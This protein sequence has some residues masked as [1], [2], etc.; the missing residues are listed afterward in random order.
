MMTAMLAHRGPDGSGHYD[1][2]HA[3]LGHR[4]LA[5]LDLSE[6]GA[7]PMTLRA[8]G[9]VLSYNGEVYNHLELRRELPEPKGGYRSTSDTEVVLQALS[10]WGLDACRRFNGMW[11]FALWDPAAR[12]LVL[13]RDRFGVKPLYFRRWRDGLAFASE[14]KPLLALGGLNRRPDPLAVTRFLCDREVDGEE[15]TFFE[16][17]SQVRAGESLVFEGPCRAP[18]ARDRYWTPPV[19][20][21]KG[22][23]D[24]L[25]AL[26]A[27]AVGLR[28]RADVP[29]ACLLSGGIDSSAV[30]SLAARSV[31]PAPLL[32]FTARYPGDA[33]D[34]WEQA[35][36]V[37]EQ[38]ANLMARGVF[39]T[40][41]SFLVDLGEVVEAQEE[42]FADGSMIAHFQIMRAVA[43]EG[44]KVLL[45]G[46]GGDEAFAGYVGTFTS[47]AAVDLARRGRLLW[48]V[49]AARAAGMGRSLWHA[50]G[51]GLKN[52]LRRSAHRWRYGRWIAASALSA[53][54]PRYGDEG[55]GVL[56]AYQERC[57]DRWSLPS[58]LHYEDR[59]SMWFGIEGR[60]PFLDYRVMSLGLCC[61]PELKIRGGVGKVVLRRG[62]QGIVPPEILMATRKMS[63]HAPIEDW[64]RGARDVVAESVRSISPDLF[65]H[66]QMGSIGADLDEGRIP[67]NLLWRLFVLSRWATRFLEEGQLQMGGRIDG[68]D[69]AFRD[70]SRA[71]T[72]GAEAATP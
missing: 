56:R 36:L 50:M 17:I 31:E 15:D 7:Q 68:V 13:S 35:R 55:A 47:A 67:S 8:G 41:S 33:R 39:P 57:V 16:G 14:I 40:A 42:P 71:D 61:P 52:G 46:Q 1:D 63:F 51:P 32:A 30:A 18:V 53:L 69:G 64:M 27:D 21:A 45:T 38:Y 37:P 59:N 24:E 60:A 72:T 66:L 12:R 34:E 25:A 23:P 49:D 29:V 11:A 3:S 28:M 20:S 58:F 54:P 70:V 44:V 43:S 65:P 48:A 10:V 9:C 62:L 2:D 4:R 22:D 26:L 5:I 19:G 6:A